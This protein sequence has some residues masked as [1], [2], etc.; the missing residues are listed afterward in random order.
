MNSNWV[1]CSAEEIIPEAISKVFSTQR[2]RGLELHG[3]SKI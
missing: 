1:D 2:Y 3:E